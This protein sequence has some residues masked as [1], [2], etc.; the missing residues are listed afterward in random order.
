MHHFAFVFLCPSSAFIAS[1]K[2][3]K[4]MFSPRTSKHRETGRRVKGRDILLLV[5]VKF[6]FLRSESS[7]GPL[8]QTAP[9]KNVFPMP[10]PYTIA[11]STVR[12]VIDDG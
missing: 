7:A 5:N 4:R 12:S 9:E 6:R 3:K 11:L 10:F 1:L 8:R 2:I